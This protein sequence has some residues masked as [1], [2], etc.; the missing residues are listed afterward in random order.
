[1]QE[2]SASMDEATEG[3]EGEGAQAAQFLNLRELEDALEEV[4]T[5]I[6]CDW[7]F[8][9]LYAFAPYVLI[10]MEVSLHMFHEYRYI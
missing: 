6:L 3:E 10:M 7:S 9:A 4:L 2:L 8:V 5:G 1:M